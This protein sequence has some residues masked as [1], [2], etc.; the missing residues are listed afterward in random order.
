M[1]SFFANPRYQIFALCAAQHLRAVAE[2]LKLR[3][4]QSR[5]MS[6]HSLYWRRREWN[7][8]LPNLS[9]ASQE[10]FQLKTGHPFPKE[11]RELGV[12]IRGSTKEVLNHHAIN[13]LTLLA[14]FVETDWSLGE[15]PPVWRKCPNN[16]F[17]GYAYNVVQLL[18]RYSDPEMYKVP[19]YGSAYMDLLGKN[20]VVPQV[21]NWIDT[22]QSRL[23]DK[24]VLAAVEVSRVVNMRPVHQCT[25]SEPFGQ[26][27]A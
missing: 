7:S 20:P 10:Q 1:N 27:V 12:W 8:F 4:I 23:S 3:G 9:P 2:R 15:Q 18:F 17:K 25:S 11:R 13:R 26:L 16:Q 19:L 22:L 6:Y 21:Q 14:E 24:L 5:P